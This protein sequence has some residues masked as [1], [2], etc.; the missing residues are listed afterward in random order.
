MIINQAALQ[1]IYKS[2]KTIYNKAFLESQPLYLK[3][4][5]EVPSSTRSEEYKWL[6]KIPRMREWVGDRVIQNLSAYGYEIKNKDFEVT[7]SVDRNDL[8]DDTIGIYNPLVQSIG[9]S[10]AM[11][12]DELIFDLL[13]KGFVNKCYDGKAFFATNH[14]D[15]KSTEQSNKGTHILTAETYGGDAKPACCAAAA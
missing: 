5:T 11:H 13:A 4:A 1:S 14:K 2:F 9:Q 15:G 8:E 12:P 6:G 3:I 7:V 10:A